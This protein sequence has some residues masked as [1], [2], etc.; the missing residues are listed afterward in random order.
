MPLH[1]R[2]S[3]K[4]GHKR[5]TRLAAAA[6]GKRRQD[7]RRR[8]G[9][10]HPRPEK[11]GTYRNSR[12]Q[13]VSVSHRAGMRWSTSAS[14][15]SRPPVWPQRRP[16]RR[17]R[18]AASLFGAFQNCQAMTQGNVGP[19]TLQQP[20]CSLGQR[21]SSLGQSALRLLD[22]RPSRSYLINSSGRCS[23]RPRLS[24]LNTIHWPVPRRRT[25]PPWRGNRRPLHPDQRG[26]PSA[27]ARRAV[28]DIWLAARGRMTAL[29]LRSVVM[30]PEPRS[31]RRMRQ[32][33]WKQF[34]LRA[35]CRPAPDAPAEQYPRI[36]LQPSLHHLPRAQ[37]RAAHSHQTVWRLAVEL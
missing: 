32:A 18:S 13:F 31:L 19:T 15:Q 7:R 37:S 10:M 21:L 8:A 26:A 35:V 33:V 6:A 22:A 3:R 12:N 4:I 20:F 5:L 14:F 9:V 16:W 24:G 23:C 28:W 25:D 1:E 2:Y 34:R 17:R 29:P 30:R 11:R 36:P 27:H